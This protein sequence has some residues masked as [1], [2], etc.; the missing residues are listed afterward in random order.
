MIV[1]L[2]FSA[3]GVPQQH[4]GNR[5]SRAMLLVII[6]DG[7]VAIYNQVKTAMCGNNVLC[8]NCDKRNNFSFKHFEKTFVDHDNY[9]KYESVQV[10]TWCSECN[11]INEFISFVLK[12]V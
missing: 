8:I 1:K 2:F 3:D 11:R 6:R 5:Y 10:I 12:F 9:C 4:I 7:N